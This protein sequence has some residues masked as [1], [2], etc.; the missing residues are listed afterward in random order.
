MSEARKGIIFSES[1]KQ[2]LREARRAYFA[3]LSVNRSY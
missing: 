1:H 3:R 2:H